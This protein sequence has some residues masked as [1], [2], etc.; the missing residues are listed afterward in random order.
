MMKSIAGLL[1]VRVD[2]FVQNQVLLHI[3]PPSALFIFFSFFLGGGG[4]EG[5]GEGLAGRLG[6]AIHTSRSKPRNC[7]C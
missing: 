7:I 3:D 5:E 2:W 4:G 6:I 1:K